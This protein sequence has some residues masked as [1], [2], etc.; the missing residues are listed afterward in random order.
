M[1]IS[2]CRI[3]NAQ[4]K[5]EHDGFFPEEAEILKTDRNMILER[6]IEVSYSLTSIIRCQISETD[7]MDIQKK[8]ESFDKNIGLE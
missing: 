8:F 6:H 1:N 3:C 7:C 2:M 4:T 5:R